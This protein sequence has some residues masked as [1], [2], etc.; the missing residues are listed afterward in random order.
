MQCPACDGVTLAKSG[1]CSSCEGQWL[2]EQHV[3]DQADGPLQYTG[4]VY[5]ERR[6]PVCDE[7]MSEPLVFDIPIDRCD[8]HGMWFDK[9]ELAEVLRRSRSD[10]WRHL[11]PAAPVHHDD[12]VD[13]LI[14]AMRIWRQK[15]T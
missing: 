4:G 11:H 9:A 15:R 12:Q 3:I 8:A 1:A 2:D 14:A 6:C 5:S 10:D 7:K 13:A